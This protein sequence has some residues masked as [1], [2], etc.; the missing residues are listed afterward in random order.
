MDYPGES[1]VK[2]PPVVQEPKE[3]GFDPW[4]RKMPWRRK[5]NPLQK[6]LNIT[7]LHIEIVMPIYNKTKA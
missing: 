3:P 4:V 5:G 1:V 2:N 7:I 6:P